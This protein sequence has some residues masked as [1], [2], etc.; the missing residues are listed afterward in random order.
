MN[1][2]YEIILSNHDQHLK[3]INSNNSL[4]YI[5]CLYKNYLV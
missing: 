5:E 3:L 2:M 1:V 4:N